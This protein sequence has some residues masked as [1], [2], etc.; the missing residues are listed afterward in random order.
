M[1][2]FIVEHLPF[3][4]FVYDASMDIVFTNSRARQFLRRHALPQEIHAVS[5][6]MFAALASSRFQEEFPGEVLIHKKI[7]D[8]PGKWTFRLAARDGTAEKIVCVYCI[9]E[10]G[11]MSM[12]LNE[13][14]QR[15]GLTRRENDVM[16]RLLHG[17]KNTDIADDLGIA[18]QTVKD[19]LSNIYQKT[20]A[21]NRF[22]LI[23][24]LVQSRDSATNDK[25]R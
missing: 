10:G 23:R 14:R 5:R 25:A 17:M 6:K 9:E 2:D 24:L 3:P 15:F 22:S 18:N 8:S 12:D 13:V 21:Q 1:I 16:R 20:G 7:D 4:V 19:H 11:P